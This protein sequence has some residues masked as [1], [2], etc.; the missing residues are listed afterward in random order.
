MGSIQPPP[1]PYKPCSQNINN[2][3]RTW[4]LGL[5][6][7]QNGRFVECIMRLTHISV[8]MCTSTLLKVYLWSTNDGKASWTVNGRRRR[9]QGTNTASGK[10]L[11]S[12]SSYSYSHT[13]YIPWQLSHGS[14]YCFLKN[15]N[16]LCL[17]I[18]STLLV[19][20]IDRSTNYLIHSWIRKK[21]GWTWTGVFISLPQ[22]NTSYWPTY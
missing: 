19:K 12:Y 14:S 15:T 3:C 9:W 16:K 7:K 17:F 20:K 22:T 10:T 21:T 4:L 11:N 2:V 8:K 6:R 5:T 13:K 1:S 18:S